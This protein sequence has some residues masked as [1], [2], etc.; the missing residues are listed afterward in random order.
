MTIP[1]FP[2]Q[3]PFEG[4]LDYIREEFEYESV[5]MLG[6]PVSTPLGGSIRIYAPENRERYIF[7]VDAVPNDYTGG[8]IFSPDQ[9][10][11][12]GNGDLQRGVVRAI[13]L[14]S[15]PQLAQAGDRNLFFALS[16]HVQ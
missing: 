13:R 11:S 1:E 10:T 4:D 12:Y 6:E 2:S 16:D 7:V 8:A 15:N 5:E 3:N 14:F 9:L